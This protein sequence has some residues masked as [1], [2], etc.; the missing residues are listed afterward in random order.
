MVYLPRCL[1]VVLTL[2]M[3]ASRPSAA[4]RFG[5]SGPSL[6][7][8]TQDESKIRQEA[9]KYRQAGDFASAEQAYEKG[10][11]RSLELRD[12]LAAVRYLTGAGACQVLEFRFR[13]A[14]ESLLRARQMAA[15]AH[16][17][18]E[19]GALAINLSSLYLQVQ[20]IDSA[21][22]SA[23]EGLESIRA[24]PHPYYETQLLLQLGRI[25]AALQDG[26]AE[27]FYA[28]AIEAARGQGSLPLEARGWDLLG[29]AW[30]HNGQWKDA[31]RALDQA[32]RLRRTAARADLPFSY[33]LLGA[34]K[35]AQGDVDSAGR[36]TKLALDSRGGEPKFLLKN[37]RGQ[38]RLARGDIDGALD[39][40]SSAIDLSAQWWRGILPAESVLAG[41][42]V[43]LEHSVFQAFVETAARQALAT[44]EA[45]WTGEAF[46][47]LE[48]NRA[49]SLRDSLALAE[50]W[51]EGLP[52]EYWEFLAR[53]RSE[54]P[55]AAEQDRLKLKLTELEAKAGMVLPNISSENFRTKNSLIHFQHGL[56]SSELFLSYSLG[57][58]R[59][60]V[61]AVTRNSVSLHR[62][63]AA[64]QIRAEVD[65]FRDAVRNGRDADRFGTKLYAELTGGLS[66]REKAKPHW[67]LS[68]GGA[69]LDLPFN[70]ITTG[71]QKAKYLIE[72]HS[73]QIVPGAFLLGRDSWPDRRNGRLLA[74]GDP[75]Y[76]AADPRGKRSSAR[77]YIGWRAQAADGQLTRLVG[78]A[79]EVES[80]AQSWNPESSTLLE[81]PAARRDRFLQALGDRPAVIHLATHVV[82]RPAQPSEAM[83]AFGLGDPGAPELLSTAEVARL[84]VPGAVVVM[85]G[86]D[87][88]GGE[89]RDGAGL[90]GLTRA[91]QIAGASAVISTHWPVRDSN[92][93][94]FASFYRHLR[95][96]PPAEA[97]RHS[98]IEMIHSGTWRAAP[99]YWAS[100]RLNGSLR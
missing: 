43:D 15:A 39:D 63:P 85:T 40:F 5:R 3:A 68:L 42:N 11:H 62:V 27:G 99:A 29:E 48:M 55:G 18:L 100:Y 90:F 66:G 51:R 56:S 89:I 59:S 92:G 20:D 22:R 87:S 50:A 46:Q 44:G 25:H 58:E 38:I 49:A 26:Q 23:D 76:N 33:A 2:W 19:S 28:R 14:F 69:L 4:A 65:V 75:I 35:L 73:L 79:A 93:A 84:R 32:F 81:G 71:D 10:F 91:W 30:L 1:C 47:A 61:W 16:A 97:L 54:Q 41:A 86:C 88:G 36:F 74:V 12:E 9:L 72:K 52:V 34:L 6:W 96:E 37:Q 13:E 17:D 60:Y 67:L 24:L 45:R 98:Q 80:S 78:S 64:G 21:V 77:P 31:E 57:K 95:T 82:F 7:W 53:L 83:I 94:I 8:G 70:A